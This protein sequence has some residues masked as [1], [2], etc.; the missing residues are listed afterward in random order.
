[1]PYGLPEI[2][3]WP[4]PPFLIFYTG[5]PDIGAVRQG[6]VPIDLV[7]YQKAAAHNVY[8]HLLLELMQSLGIA[9]LT[10]HLLHEMNAGKLHLR[11]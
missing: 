8:R 3:R 7:R 9:L 6:R 5:N 10:M 1:M 2:C 4:D 11:I